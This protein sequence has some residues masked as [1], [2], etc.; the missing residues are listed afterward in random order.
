MSVKK[1]WTISV[2][3]LSLVLSLF[4]FGKAQASTTV[5]AVSVPNI[6]QAKTYWCWAASGSAL[7]RSKGKNISQSEVSYAIFKNYNDQRASMSQLR[8]G[9]INLGYNATKTT[10]DT[11]LNVSTVRNHLTNKRAIIVEYILLG[12]NSGHV[13]VIS[14]HDSEISQLEVMDPQVGRKVYYK[15]AY[16]RNNSVFH[17]YSSIY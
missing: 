14:G 7:L 3:I 1:K 12:T 13:V 4:S 16:F 10:N 6:L 9:I 5:V 11:T 15:D 17:W 8:S 2:I